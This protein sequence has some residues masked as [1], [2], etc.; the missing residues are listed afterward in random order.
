MMIDARSFMRVVSPECGANPRSRGSR[1]ARSLAAARDDMF[2]DEIFEH[3]LQSVGAI[4]DAAADRSGIPQA[5]LFLRFGELA[6]PDVDV[7]RVLRLFMLAQAA[8]KCGRLAESAGAP[9]TEE[10]VV[11]HDEEF[12]RIDAADSLVNRFTEKGALLCQRLSQ[13]PM[14]LRDVPRPDVTAGD[15]AITIDGAAI[16]VN[17]IDV[18]M[19]REQAA[20]GVQRLGKKDVVGIEPTEDLAVRHC[21]SLLPRVG[22]SFVLATVPVRNVRLVAADDL[23]GIVGTAAVEHDVLEVWIILRDHAF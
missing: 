2:R 4:H 8:E 12:R 3:H 18:L 21:E 6:L 13:C 19:L 15:V 22:L 17:E 23:H 10:E 7:A 5:V 11:I 14:P 1:A 9:H 16:A 20:D